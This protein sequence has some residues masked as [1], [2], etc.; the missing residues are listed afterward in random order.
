[1]PGRLRRSLAYRMTLAVLLLSL[2]LGVVSAA[3]LFA[4][5]YRD[6]VRGIEQDLDRIGQVDVQSVSADLWAMDMAQLQIYLNALSQHPYVDQVHIEVKGQ[7]IA[8]AGNRVPGRSISR[9]FPLRHTLGTRTMELGT[10]HVQFSL[11][12]VTRGLFKA[13]FVRL[14]FQT[15]QIFAVAI[16]VL[17][18]LRSLV[19][20]RLSALDKHLGRIG[21]G[22]LEAAL[23]LPRSRLYTGED[24]LDR[25][26][27]T[28]SAMAASLRAA[29]GELESQKA[30]LAVTLRS[31][32]D[33]VITTDTRGLVTMMNAAAEDLTGWTQESAAGRPL[34]EVF[35]IVDEGT[36]TM[37]DNPVTRVLQTGGVVE[38]VN[39]TALVRRDGSEIVIADSAAPIRERGGDIVG[40]VLVFRDVTARKRAE[41]ELRKS[42]EIFSHFMEH[43]PIYVFFKDENIRSLRLSRNYEA[44]LGKPLAEL[45]GKNMDDLFPSELAKSMVADDM[46]VLREG[47]EVTVDEDLNGRVYR[48]IKFPVLLEA[49]LRCLA[50]YTIDVTDQK[51]EQESLARLNRNHELILGSVAEGILGLDLQGNHTFVNPVAARL[52]GYEAEE[53]L[54]RNSHE[55]WH[56]TKPDGTPCPGET[57][58]VSA[59]YRDGVV[60]RAASDVFWRKDGTCF[61]VEYVSTPSWEQGRLV[62]AVVTFS[63]ITGRLRSAEEQ[64]RL[65]E[66][67]RQA[68]KMEAV[69]RLAGGVAHD[70]NNLT[71]IVLGY[72][73]ML[74]GRLPPE[75]QLRKY[76]EQ[77]VEAGRRSAA[78]T[79]QLLAFSRKQTLQPEVLDLNALLENLEKM[80]GRLIGED[81]ELEFKLAAGLGRVTAD[82]GQIEQ[83]VTNLVL[84]ARDA[85]PH[86]GRL[87]IE[88]ADVLIDALYSQ[89]HESV[90]P[91]RY[92]LLALTDS[93]C[94]MDKATMA[95][96]FEPFF[97]TKE[98]GK[99]TGLGLATTYGI[100]KQSGGYIW[101]YSEPGRGATFKIYLP[102]TEARPE[103]RAVETGGE[104]PRGRGERVLLVEDEAP[105]RALCETVLTQLGYR[106]SAAGSGPE[107]LVLVREQGLVP[108]LLVTDVIM[109]GMSGAVLAQRLRGN[110]PGLRVLYM[111]GYP[112]EAIAPHGILDAGTPFIQKPF[113]ERT[114]ALKLREALGK[115]S[116]A[117]GSSRRVLMI[118][119]DEQYRELVRHFCT[120]GG[121]VFSGVDSAAAAL[122][123]LAAQPFDV[124]LVDLNIP[125]TSGERVLREIRAAGHTAP[126]IVLTGDVAS[127]DMAVL[128]P[129]GV[130]Q[131]QG[132]SSSM[133]PLVRAIE[134]ASR[135]ASS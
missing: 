116:A 62:G 81:V 91:G 80:L 17:A 58:Q 106:V 34:A 63:D 127:A 109:P 33:G 18:L 25:V 26:A 38:L 14:V 78:L 7:V 83:V 54:G 21:A 67:L 93:G 41:A 103:A 108:D 119:D 53:L 60:G 70:F 123:A 134:A 31:I 88:T 87:T 10:L 24:E 89:G 73:E 16:C 97:T 101:A 39:H 133:E 118:D 129:L 135:Q 3:G 107:A 104:V 36:H 45:L 105:L 57:C 29:F 75:D 47:R 71:A 30:R 11:A 124:L 66:Q 69:G 32:G 50:G 76:A 110:R 128:A 90:V 28:V 84:N 43:S 95:R 102:R 98:K 59:A 86:G 22:D 65:E 8:A 48:T 132:K 4:L 1:M 51:R 56:H 27:G 40:V 92:V 114:L 85:M 111:S 120:K 100:V 15:V 12:G 122:A 130:V 126:A 99:G 6:T 23:T 94:G 115:T 112:D 131:A 79:R 42:E 20:S 9:V 13:M 68:Q 125:G 2:V 74:L 55:I 77:I 72:G 37:S 121:H 49:G 44:L 96:L 113:T 117:A 61:P 82:P 64:A 19:T 35:P 52:L 5:Q 46:R